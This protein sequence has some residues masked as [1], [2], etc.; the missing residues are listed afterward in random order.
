MEAL[1]TALAEA[2]GV[3]F[4]PFLLIP[5]LLLTGL[6]LTIRSGG[7]QFRRLGEGLRIGFLE[8]RE[9]DSPGDISHFQA[10]MLQ[11]AATVG[12]GNLAG[13][14]TAI[15]AGGPGAVF[16]MWITGLVGMA[17]KYAEG[18]LGVRFRRVD[19]NG[20]QTGGPMTYLADGIGGRLGKYLGL[21]FA[22]ATAVAAFGIGNMVQSN[23]VSVALDSQFGIARPVT[24][25]VLTLL[26]AV[27]L[28][29]GI[30]GI[31]RASA[32]LVPAMCVVYVIAGIVV[33]VINVAEIPAALSLI[34][35]DAFTGTAAAG[36]FAGSAVRQA[37]QF[38]VARGIFSNEAGLG[39]GGIGAA[40]AQT[41]NPVRQALVGMTQTFIDTI[42][43]CSITALAIIT[44]GAWTSGE[45]STALSVLAF[46]EGLP[47]EWGGAVVAVASALFAYTTL[48]GWGYFGERS[49]ERLL[50]VRAITPY[51][52]LFV[53]A[54]LVGALQEI[55]IVWNF[56]DVA[57]GLMA[58][59]N[60]IGL[61]LL[62]G[63]VVRETREYL[64][65]PA[66]L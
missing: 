20:Q 1:E 40:A 60:L 48:L 5:L 35:S 44:T 51:R 27:V 63:L 8:R 12:N 46:S 52:L 9:K 29:S 59:P 64:R 17:T 39:T 33:L 25:V 22:I 41:S 6:F 23:S 66:R 58:L 18:F 50:G 57:N 28:F 13:V 3:V 37:V 43:V 56:A 47:G 49:I 34:F 61:L 65:D 30:K 4:G 7:I 10:L 32:T 21:F 11:L 15:F 16:W 36:G 24:G 2:A 54:V 14:A 42:L 31:G 45:D 62:S 19:A 53:A 38:G 26:T 55:T